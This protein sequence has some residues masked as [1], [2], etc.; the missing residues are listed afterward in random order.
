MNGVF[1]SPEYNHMSFTRGDWQIDQT[2]EPVRALR[3]AG[4]G[5]HV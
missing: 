2:A 3:V 1:T 5:L 4:V